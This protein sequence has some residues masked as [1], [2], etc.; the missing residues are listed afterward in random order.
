MDRLELPVVGNIFPHRRLYIA[1][2]PVPVDPTPSSLRAAFAILRALNLSSTAEKMDNTSA[3][4]PSGA[5]LE[6]TFRF[7]SH[8]VLV[9]RQGA[10][11]NTLCCVARSPT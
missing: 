9:G 6:V 10:V 4:H 8:Q 11:L 2:E 1:S 5:P 3:A 7:W